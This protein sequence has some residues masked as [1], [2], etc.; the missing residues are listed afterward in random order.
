MI[1]KSDWQTVHRQLLAD[2]RL[3]VGPPPTAEEMLAYTRGELSPEDQA[4]VRERLIS[5][6]ELLR[7]LTAEFPAEGAEPSDPDY[8][9]DEEYAVHW[10]SLQKRMPRAAAGGRVLQF[11]RWTAGVAA[12]IALILGG[13]LWQAIHRIAQPRVVADQQVLFPDGRRGGGEAVTPLTGHGDSALLVIPLSGPHDYQR[14]RLELIDAESRRTLWRSAILAPPE[15][16]T[17]AILVPR[18]FLHPGICRIAVYGISGATEERLAT[19]SFRVTAGR[20]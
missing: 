17:F 16:D 14:Y 11:W 10:A 19:S 18:A 12:A 9:S 15:N 2:D 3:K 4:R 6:P 7:T 13:A 20:S 8:L 1:T 5:Y